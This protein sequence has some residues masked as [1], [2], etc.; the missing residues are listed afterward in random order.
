ML[1]AILAIWFGYKKAKATGRNPVLWAAICGAAF[2]GMQL[3]TALVIGITVGIGV[4][5]RGWPETIYDDY[6]WIVTVISIVVSIISLLLVFKY[7]DRIP[8]NAPL[9]QQ[10]PPPPIFGDEQDEQ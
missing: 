7:L 3:L 10:P 9:V 4:E 5:L 2:I 1:L 6:Q 8:E